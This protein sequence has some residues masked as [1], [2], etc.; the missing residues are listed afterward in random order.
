MRGVRTRVGPAKLIVAIIEAQRG[1][2]LLW[3]PVAM[4][5]GIGGYFGLTWEPDFQAYLTLIASGFVVAVFFASY[6]PQ[7]NITYC[8]YHAD[9]NR[10]YPFRH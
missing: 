7:N 10:L 1:T 2:L 4:S 6:K 3:M 8:L 5:F 9:T